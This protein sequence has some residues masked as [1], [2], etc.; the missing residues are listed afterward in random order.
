MIVNYYVMTL[1]FKFCKH[2]S[3]GC[4]DILKIRLN[5]NMRA[6]GINKFAKSQHTCVH[7]FSSYA[8]VCAQIFTKNFLVVHYSVMNIDFKFHKDLIFR[9]RDICKIERCFF[10]PALYT[11][12]KSDIYLKC[13][14]FMPE[15]YLK[16]GKDVP[17]MYLRY[18]RD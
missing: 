14:W 8:R 5:I 11:Q 9:C 15:F 12:D 6:R 1:S 3:F 17:A 18:S 4:G 10:W 16:Y 13:A 2:S 7:V